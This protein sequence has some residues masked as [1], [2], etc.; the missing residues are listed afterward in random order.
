MGFTIETGISGVTVF[1]QGLL[2]FFS[3]C[4]LPLVPLYIGYLAGGAK[5]VDE[6]GVIHYRRSKVI[7]NTFFCS[8]S[9]LRF[10]P[11][12]IWFYCRRKVFQRKPGPVR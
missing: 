3:P 1:L 6:D 8:G 11:F 2:S 7:V 4:V 10:L 5:T 9:Q 12:R